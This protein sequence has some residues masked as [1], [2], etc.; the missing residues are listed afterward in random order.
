MEMD[1]KIC[2]KSL[3]RGVRVQ[4]SLICGSQ[5]H[6]SC[7]KLSEHDLQRITEN[8]FLAVNCESCQNH[9]N[10]LKSMDLKIGEMQS[11][12]KKMSE[13][14]NSL[15]SEWRIHKENVKQ[16][17]IVK[18]NVV[19]RSY[20]DVAKSSVI[21]RPKNKSQDSEKT[22]AEIKKSEVPAGVRIEKMF[23]SK[24]GEIVISCENSDSSHKIKEVVEQK[25]S[26]DYDVVV[27]DSGNPRIIIKGVGEKYEDLK[28]FSLLGDQN[29]CFRMLSEVKLVTY[30]DSKKKRNKFDV[31]LEVP[32]SGLQSI[33]DEK[34]V[35]IGWDKCEVAENMYIK[36]CYKCLGFNHKSEECKEENKKC[37]ICAGNH[38]QKDCD[39]KDKVGCINC[40]KAKEELHLN[41]LNVHHNAFDSS[42]P[43]YKRKLENLRSLYF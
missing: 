1:C 34:N 32:K 23:K 16:P 2:N 38:M 6:P 17:K 3:S 11:V 4:C 26:V 14:V 35:F 18:E 30:L 24:G 21:V 19:V 42:C 28:L 31:V 40:I 9:L 10:K 27:K 29:E 39:S 8:P 13:D 7:L 20:S 33:I 12:M 22:R 41:K 37:S 36:R 25:M 15:V 5:F 43:V